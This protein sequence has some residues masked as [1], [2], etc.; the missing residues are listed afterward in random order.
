MTWRAG[1]VV[2]TMSLGLGG[3]H[4]PK[5][6][7]VLP[8]TPQ[9]QAQLPQPRIEEP[10][11]LEVALPLITIETLKLE[12]PPQ[13]DTPQPKVVPRRRPT[14]AGTA[15]T[16][17]TTPPPATTPTPEVETPATVTPPVPTTPLLSE[18]LTDDRR[19]QYEADIAASEARAKAAVRRASGRRGLTTRQKEAVQRINT[20]LQQ[21]EESKGKD[22]V[23]AHELARRADLFGQDLLKSLQ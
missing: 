2:A 4:T 8:P 1:V 17:A 3:C 12:T 13:I 5:K 23:T 19:R 7:F 20:F 18:I 21:V 6:Q 9:V 14:P 16:T 10:P 15:G 11:H 22:L